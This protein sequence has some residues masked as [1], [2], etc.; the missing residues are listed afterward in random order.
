MYFLG[1]YFPKKLAELLYR[2][3]FNKE[4]NWNAPQD[5]N[6]K[7][8]W[9]A[10][11]TDTKLWSLLADKYLVRNYVKQKGLEHILTKI[12]S[13]WVD[14]KE[15]SFDM[16]PNKFI[17]KC[18][19]DAGTSKIIEN[20][21]DIDFFKIKNKL[22]NC[23]Y[24]NFGIKTAEPHYLKIKRLIFAEEL[25]INDSVFSDSLIDYKFWSFYGEAKYCHVIFNK[26]VYKNKCAAIYKLPEW[27]YQKGKL[28]D[29]IKSKEIPK[30]KLLNEMLNIVYLL[31]KDFPQCRVDLYESSNKIFFGEL[32]FTSACGR[33]TTYTKN[34]LNELGNN[35]YI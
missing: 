7:I 21:S 13:V 26:K 14:P 10:F 17:L 20:K 31:S 1:R 29:N 11:N 19:H 35:I 12:Y 15:I 22:I 25:I 6:E 27:E 16:L 28:K 3:T 5:L 23:F 4:I 24:D 2:N 18:N 32:T 34:F 30:P 9:L 8:N 33:I